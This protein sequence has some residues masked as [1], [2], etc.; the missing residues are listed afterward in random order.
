MSRFKCRCGFSLRISNVPEP[1]TWIAYAGDIEE[2]SVEA[3]FEANKDIIRENDRFV[4][5]HRTLIYEC[6]SCGWLTWYRGSPDEAT[7]FKPTVGD[8]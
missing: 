8:S 2:A 1:Q 4:S 7:H 3:D 5:E 6:P